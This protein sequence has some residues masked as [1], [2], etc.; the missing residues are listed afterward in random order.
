MGEK[1]SEATTIDI[2]NP[3]Q[4][5]TNAKELARRVLAVSKEIAKPTVQARKKKKPTRGKK[6]S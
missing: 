6:G 5:M 4:A 2:P 3:E 1:N